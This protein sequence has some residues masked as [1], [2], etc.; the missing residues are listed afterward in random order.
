MRSPVRSAAVRRTTLA[1]AAA[2]AVLSQGCCFPQHTA[3]TL[4]VQIPPCSSRSS[5][6]TVIGCAFKSCREGLSAQLCGPF[7]KFEGN[8][9]RNPFHTE[10]QGHL[11]VRRLLE[12]TDVF[13][14]PALLLTLAQAS[15]NKQN[16]FFLQN[17]ASTIRD[18]AAERNGVAGFNV[19][20]PFHDRDRWTDDKLV[21]QADAVL[22]SMAAQPHVFE[23]RPPLL[24]LR[25]HAELSIVATC[26][27]AHVSLVIFR[28]RRTAQ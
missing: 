25:P 11:F 6:A 1:T 17:E 9:V 23:A 19:D 3:L 22:A 20:A 5:L 21:V 16:G 27:G 8:S 14:R 24:F 18:C 4:R 15:D 28:D 10:Q 12:P 26:K 7:F 13:D 2:A